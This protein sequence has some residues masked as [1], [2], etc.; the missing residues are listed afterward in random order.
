MSTTFQDKL[1][2][3][4]GLE[5]VDLYWLTDTDTGPK[6]IDPKRLDFEMMRTLSNFIKRTNGGAVLLDGLE[7][8]VVENSFDRVL[9]FIKQVTDLS[10]V[11]EVTLIVPVTAG[12]LGADELSMLRKEFDRVI[13]TSGRASASA[14]PPPPPPD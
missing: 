2:K 4:F 5:G 1:R 6:S 9:R 11:H 14:T 3:E 7:Y 13:E 8:L 10:S 12:S